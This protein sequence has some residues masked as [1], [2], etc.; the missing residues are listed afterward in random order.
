[1]VEIEHYCGFKVE[2]NPSKREFQVWL[3]K[4]KILT[5]PT[6][7][8][9]EDKIDKLFKEAEP[10]ARE[11]CAS[12]NEVSS[13]KECPC[14]SGGKQGWLDCREWIDYVKASI[15]GRKEN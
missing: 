10:K 2:Y 12:D 5:A 11:L 15:S 7:D 3:E 1:M 9:I 8:E 13:C 14:W 4:K 6:Q